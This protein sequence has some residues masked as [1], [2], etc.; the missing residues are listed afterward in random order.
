MG[1]INFQAMIVSNYQITI[2]YE[3]RKFLDLH[4][5]DMLDISI[6]G[7]KTEVTVTAPPKEM[8]KGDQTQC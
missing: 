5:G 4:I 8:H 3:T 1:L 6:L 2:P 7:I